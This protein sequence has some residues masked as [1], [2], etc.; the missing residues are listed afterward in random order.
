[1][2]MNEK[3]SQFRDKVLCV[4]A[5]VVCWCRW[6]DERCENSEKKW[7]WR[8]IKNGCHCLWKCLRMKNIDSDW[9][10]I[11]FMQNKTMKKNA[12]K[13]TSDTMAV[14]FN[15]ILHP[16][17]MFYLLNKIF[18]IHSNEFK[19]LLHKKIYTYAHA[20]HTHTWDNNIQ[21]HHAM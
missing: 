4:Y 3:K 8:D 15:L 9:V 1:M 20:T 19:T 7:E 13:I 5:C 21:N 18:D 2:K 11:W 12:Q 16:K 6:L 10:W 14:Y 17:I